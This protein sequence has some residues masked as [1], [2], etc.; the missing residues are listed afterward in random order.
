MI[1]IHG[2]PATWVHRLGTPV[3]GIGLWGLSPLCEIGISRR[4]VYQM[5]A[6][7]ILAHGEGSCRRANELAHLRGTTAGLL[8]V[9]LTRP[10]PHARSCGERARQRIGLPDFRLL[11]AA[12]CDCIQRFLDGW[13]AFD[14]FGGGR[15]PRIVNHNSGN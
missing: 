8:C 14:D 3:M 6:S 11:V 15:I 2:R 10:D 13:L 4:S 1:Q 5:T 12:R 7:K 9:E